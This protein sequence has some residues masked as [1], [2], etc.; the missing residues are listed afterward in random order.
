LQE[1][2][3]VLLQGSASDPDGDAITYRWKDTSGKLLEVGQNVTTKLLTKGKHL[4]TLEVSDGNDTA[5]VT[6]TV[7]INPKPSTNQPGFEGLMLAAA[8]VLGLVLVR[9]RRESRSGKL[10]QGS[11]AMRP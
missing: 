5:S 4:L 2:K 9:R 1:G 3:G 10:D 11:K 7:I 6:I 8:I